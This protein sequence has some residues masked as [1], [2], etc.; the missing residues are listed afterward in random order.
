M[1]TPPDDQRGGGEGDRAEWTA[2]ADHRPVE[3]PRLELEVD[4][5]DQQDRVAHDELARGW[6]LIIEVAVKKTPPKACAGM[7]PG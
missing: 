3:G 6:T 7:T 4:E 2:V 5:V 1:T